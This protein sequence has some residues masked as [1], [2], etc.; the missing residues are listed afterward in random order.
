MVCL[1]CMIA[2]VCIFMAQRVNEE[3]RPGKMDVF[4]ALKKVVFVP[5]VFCAS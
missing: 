2:I 1:L 4:C 3:V 5:G